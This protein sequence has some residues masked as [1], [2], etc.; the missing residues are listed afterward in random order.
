MCVTHIESQIWTINT[1]ICFSLFQKP[2]GVLI[3]KFKDFIP[4]ESFRGK[5]SLLTLLAL[6]FD[7]DR[8]KKI[9]GWMDLGCF[10]EVLKYQMQILIHNLKLSI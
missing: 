8:R 2:I 9:D 5:Y 4:H 3:E 10:G 7:L 6:A 1:F